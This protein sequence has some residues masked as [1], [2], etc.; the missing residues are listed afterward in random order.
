MLKIFYKLIIFMTLFWL[1]NAFAAL[2]ESGVNGALIDGGSNALIS[3]SQNSEVDGRYYFEVRNGEVK[4]INQTPV[5]T[6]PTN[7]TINENSTLIFSNNNSNQLSITD[8]DAGT[9]PVKVKLTI[10][11][12]TLTLS[13]TT[14]LTFTNGTETNDSEM[15]FTGTVANINTALAGM[16]FNPTVDFNGN[17]TLSIETNDQGN[18]GAGGA[19]TDTDTINIIIRSVNNAPSFTQGAD[20]TVDEDLGAKTVNNWATN[21]SAGPSNEASQTLNFTVTN[22][23]NSLFAAQPAID[24]NGNLSFTTAAN[25]AGIA[26]VSVVLSDGIDSSVAQNFNITIR[27]VNDEPINTVPATQTINENATLSFSSSNS[28]QISITDSDAGSN[29]IIVKLTTTNGALTLSGNTGLRFM[30]GTGTNDAEMVFTGTVTDIN[31]ALEGMIFTPIGEFYG[32]ATIQVEI[33]DQSSFGALTDSDTINITVNPV[34]DI[35]SFTKGADQI[36]YTNSGTQTIENWATNISAGPSNE[37]SQTLS[38][39]VTND[40]NSR[41]SIQ[42]VIDANGNLSFTPTAAGSAVV[43]VVLSDGI[44]SSVAQNFNIT[45]RD[46]NDEPINTVPTIQTINEDST[47]TFSNENSNQIS[48]IDSDA[49]TNPVKVKLTTTN[50]TLTLSGNTGLTFITGTNEAEMVFTG[51]VT[52][53][54]TALE[55][56]IFNPSAEF[57]GDATIQIEVDDQSSFGALIDTDTINITVNPVNDIPSFT[58]GADQTVY[59]NSGTQTIENWATNISAG[60]SNEAS[61]TLSFTVTNDNNSRFSIQ[62]VIDANGNLSFT[63][64]AAGSAVVTVVLSDGIDTSAAQ[65]FNIKINAVN[66][67]PVQQQPIEPEK[68]NNPP[69]LASISNQTIKVDE[70][71]ELTLNATDP[72]GNTLTF[73]LSDAPNGASIKDGILTWKADKAGVFN[74]TVR[75][76]DNG[77]P[78]KSDQMQ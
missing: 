14:G 13:G 37:A 65:S 10:N 50:G 26:V 48:I 42:P 31:T 61:Q 40:N 22:D 72:D 25:A 73:S 76:T 8:I 46:V 60:P 58:K 30:T 17:S 44:D 75:V 49:G 55:G 57:Y 33:D 39:T 7:Q 16:S 77:E 21:I 68:V 78:A 5:N 43:T 52:D 9:N 47:L 51:T 62:P 11:N 6:V 27:D 38:F 45:I 64:T 34:N 35:P 3:N 32:N 36:V 29:P 54:N 4:D 18:T 15:E 41:F 63:P 23:N 70:T 59:T 71:L 53:V 69:T 24:A 28:N 20:Q 12:G 19:L 67:P 66:P 56:I 74:F 2:P 1:Q